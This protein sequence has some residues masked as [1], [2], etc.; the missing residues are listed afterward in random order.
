MK[1]IYLKYQ[2]KISLKLH[3]KSM[4]IIDVTGSTKDT[5]NFKLKTLIYGMEYNNDQSLFIVSDS[6]IALKIITT[7]WFATDNSQYHYYYAHF[8]QKYFDGIKIKKQENI[9]Q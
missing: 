5:V 8:T 3:S 9:S 1:I 4:K 2:G 6:A 7:G